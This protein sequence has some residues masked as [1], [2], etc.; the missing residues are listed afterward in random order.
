VKV[1]TSLYE[2]A[3]GEEAL[4]RLEEV[5]YAKVLADPV[6]VGNRELASAFGGQV[7]SAA[8]V[9]TVVRK[10]WVQSSAWRRVSAKTIGCLGS[11][12]GVG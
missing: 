4:H 2:H 12:L 9:S 5:F 1:R 3:G 6:G 7:G 10:R 11:G 8:S